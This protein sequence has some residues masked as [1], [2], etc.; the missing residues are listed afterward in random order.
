MMKKMLWFCVA[1]CPAI[2]MLLAAKPATVVRRYISIQDAVDAG[3][4]KLK[5]HGNGRGY[6][7]YCIDMEISN[8]LH[9]SGYYLLESGRRLDSKDSN[10]QD[11]L[12]VKEN[13]IP[14]AAGEKKHISIFGFCCQLHHHAPKDTSTYSV[15]NMADPSLVMLAKFLDGSQYPIS[16]MQHA[17]WVLSD[18]NQLASVTPDKDEDI[19]DLIDMLAKIKNIEVPWYRIYYDKADTAHV[20]S[21]NHNRVTGK[22][23]YFLSNNGVVNISIYTTKGQFVKTIKEGAANPDT[24][25]YPMALDVRGWSKGQYLVRVT[26]DDKRILEKKFEL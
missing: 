18:N 3:S 12:V 4:I 23:S 24:Y 7:G 25:T 11:I 21:G 5:I 15:G 8:S 6:S 13:H 26:Q 20:F 10:T 2:I 17:I 1:I 19:N 9:D 22:L 14:L 16:P